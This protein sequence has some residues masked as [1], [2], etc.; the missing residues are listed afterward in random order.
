MSVSGT[1][2]AP[3]RFYLLRYAFESSAQSW[4]VSYVLQKTMNGLSEM[5]CSNHAVEGSYRSE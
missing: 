3:V 1:G 5:S 2:N 4:I